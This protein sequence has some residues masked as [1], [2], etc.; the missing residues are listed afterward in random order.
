MI[1][2]ILHRLK[3]LYSRYF[4]LDNVQTLNSKKL[5]VYARQCLGISLVPPGYSVELGCAISINKLFQ[6][7]TGKQI[8]GDSSSYGLLQS[9]IN[10]DTFAE[11]FSPL[12]GDIVISATGTSILKNSPLA[13][14]HVGLVLNKG[15]ASNT[16]NLGLWER[17]YTLSSWEAR[18]KT[19]GGYP[20]RYFRMI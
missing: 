15:I 20:M 2:Y 18:Y 5:A 17:N 7:M 6:M 19:Y 8:G 13:H 16:S 11:V 9:L 10:S 12:E 14:G 3:I 1:E 4:V